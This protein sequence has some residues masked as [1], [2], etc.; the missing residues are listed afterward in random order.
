MTPLLDVRQDL[1]YSIRLLARNPGFALA[2]ILTIALGIGVNATLFSIF[3]AVAL[4][5]LP[6]AQPDQVVRVKRWFD[7]GSRGDSQYAFSFP[8]YTNLRDQNRVFA[9]VVVSS[10]IVPVLVDSE[11]LQGQLVS[12]NYFSGLGI[13]AELGRTFA[14]DEDRTPGANSVLVLS[15]S[16]WKRQFNEDAQAI[17]RTITIND[18]IFTVIGVVPKNFSGTALMPQVPD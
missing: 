2:A 15:H 10:S 11:R 9:D 1:A 18:T 13:R 12:A 5:P 14:K 6:I 8:E 16:F 3:N 7:T 4:K 17:G